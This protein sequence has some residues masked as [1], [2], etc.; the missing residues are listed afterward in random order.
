GERPGER[1]RRQRR[2]PIGVT[3]V[4]MIVDRAE[5]LERIVYTVIQLTRDIVQLLVVAVDEAVELGGRDVETIIEA[6][7]VCAASRAEMRAIGSKR[8]DGCVEL[9]LDRSCGRLSRHEIDGAADRVEARH[10][11]QRTFHELDLREIGGVQYAR[12]DVARA[13]RDAVVED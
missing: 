11:R 10:D 12:G 13:G 3:V 4:T 1:R 9:A 7:Y 2:A 5:H 6:L 8:I